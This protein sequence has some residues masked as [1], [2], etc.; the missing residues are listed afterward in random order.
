MIP[1]NRFV[2]FSI[3]IAYSDKMDSPFLS[4]AAAPGTIY[5]HSFYVLRTILQL[6]F[7]KLQ[8]ERE[9]HLMLFPEML[10]LLFRRGSPVR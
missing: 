2:M 7:N 5:C 10:V 6:Y 9:Q 8:K 1:G 3:S 4:G